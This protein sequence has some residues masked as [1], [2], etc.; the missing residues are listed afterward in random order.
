MMLVWERKEYCEILHD[1]ILG[2][3]AGCEVH[4]D[5]IV[6]KGRRLQGTA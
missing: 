1:A 2:R 4:H 3:E 6:G 5:V